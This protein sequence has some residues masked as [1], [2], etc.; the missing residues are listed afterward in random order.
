MEILSEELSKEQIKTKL[1]EI[2]E[3][4]EI[5]EV[6]FNN[7]RSKSLRER[8]KYRIE[9]LKASQKQAFFKKIKVECKQLI[10]R[11]EEAFEEY[12]EMLLNEKVKNIKQYFQE[13]Y[14]K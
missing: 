8:M 2:Q 7:F 4:K 12:F 3:K 11:E 5:Q 6:E 14:V 9:I 1:K 13:K 10:G